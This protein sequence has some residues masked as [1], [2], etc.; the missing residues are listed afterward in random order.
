MTLNVDLNGKMW[1]FNF[2]H[3]KLIIGPQIQ[4][5]EQKPNP[6]HYRKILGDI[7]FGIL[8]LR[9]EERDEVY[10][11]VCKLVIYKLEKTRSALVK[12]SND[13]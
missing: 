12:V 7:V 13:T 8:G 11:S 5:R 9:Q 1:Q 2:I 4:I 6:L 3:S 10:W